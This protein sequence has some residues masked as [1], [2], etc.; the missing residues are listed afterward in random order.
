MTIITVAALRRRL[1]LNARHSNSWRAALGYHRLHPNS[2]NAVP[3]HHRRPGYSSGPDCCN[4]DGYIVA[5]RNAAQQS[6]GRSAKTGSAASTNSALRETAGSSTERHSA[7]RAMNTWAPRSCVA[8]EYSNIATTRF[9]HSAVTRYSRAPA[10]E[11]LNYYVDSQTGPKRCCS[12]PAAERMAL[13]KNAVLRRFCSR[14]FQSHSNSDFRQDS[15]SGHACWPEKR[16]SPL[17]ASQNSGPALRTIAA[18]RA[19]AVGTEPGSKP[20]ADSG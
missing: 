1:P 3:V 10:P 8:A 2:W 14:D 19:V 13:A 4:L 16:Y 11:L 15:S 17:L 12:P 6:A 7:R 9:R 5:A 18:S 20:W